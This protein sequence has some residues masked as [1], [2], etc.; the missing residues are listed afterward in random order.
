[1]SGVRI[2]GASRALVLGMVLACT[3]SAGPASLEIPPLVFVSGLAGNAELYRL[4]GDTLTRLTTN[5]FAESDP[6]SAAGRLAF[7][8]NRDGN[9]EVYLADLEAQSPRRLTTDQATDGEPAIA[10][11]GNVVAFVSMRSGTPRIWLVDVL[12]A[13]PAPLQTGSA[14]FVPERA[15]AWNPSG[16]RI[17]F[18]SVSTGTSQVFVVS[19]AGG[20]PTQLTHESGGAFDPVW[21]PGGE[22]VLYSTSLGTQ[23]VRRVPA[24]GGDATTFAEDARGLTISDCIAAVCL[25]VAGPPGAEADI[26]M[27]D[28]TNGTRRLTVAG[29]AGGRQPGFLRR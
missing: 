6:H 26:L 12:G 25:A 11:A 1:M 16:E 4:R 15:P 27:L 13:S 5:T 19:A 2:A 9:P 10:P 24:G 22:F 29:V 18:T 23:P 3:E 21:A 8:S 7:V 17:A 14:S 28:R 20:T